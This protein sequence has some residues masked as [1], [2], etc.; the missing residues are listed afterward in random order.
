MSA[1]FVD[2]IIGERIQFFVYENLSNFGETFR[3]K[4][5]VHP[6]NLNDTNHTI[7]P[8]GKTGLMIQERFEKL[9]NGIFTVV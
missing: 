2:E 1:A 8:F 5:I 3:G 7:L 9:Y 6:E 4:K